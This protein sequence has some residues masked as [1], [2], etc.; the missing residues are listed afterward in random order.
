[1]RWYGLC[2]TVSQTDFTLQ[3]RL[4]NVVYMQRILCSGITYP[5]P[6]CVRGTSF[7]HLSRYSRIHCNGLGSHPTSEGEVCAESCEFVSSHY[8]QIIK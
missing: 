4:L 8:I 3:R 1:M 2:W 5:C 6:L 7:L